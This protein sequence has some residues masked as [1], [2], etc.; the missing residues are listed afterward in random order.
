M[1]PE[2]S[3]VGRWTCTILTSF[4]CTATLVGE[5]VG[6][7]VVISRTA[8]LEYQIQWVTASSP[9]GISQIWN[10]VVPPPMYVRY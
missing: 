1:A 10:D 4:G 6:E 2:P 9:R 7:P 8:K 5:V 3:D